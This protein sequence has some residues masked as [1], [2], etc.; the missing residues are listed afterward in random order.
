[1]NTKLIPIAVVIL[2]ASCTLPGARAQDFGDAVLNRVVS[3]FTSE[4]AVLEQ[5]AYT[6]P[7]NYAE[8]ICCGDGTCGCCRHC[9]GSHDVWGSVEYLMWWAKGTHMPPLVTTSDPGTPLFQAGILGLSTTSV[10]FGNEL[11][12]NE[13]QNGGRVTFGL[14]L[15]P[16]HDVAMGGRFFGLGGDTTR[17]SQASTG[18]PILAIPFFSPLTGPAASLIAYP[19]A[20]TGNVNVELSTH[21]IMGADAFVEIMMHRDFRR[22]VDFVGGYEFF[23]LDDLLQMNSES[24]NVIPGDPLNGQVVGLNDRFL[25]RNQFHGGAVGLRGRMANGCWSL[26]VLGQVALGNM[27]Q[28]ATINGTTVITQ[29]GVSNTFAGGLLAAPTNSGEFEQDS[30]CAIPQIN[31]NLHYHVTP[32]LSFHIGYNIMWLTSVA[33]SAEQVDTTVNPFLPLGPERPRF[34][35]Q[36][37]EYWLQG[38]NWG[39]NWDF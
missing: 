31:G 27:H 19:G 4:P 15:D 33:L 13:M 6:P 35:F 23:R 38:M 14:W 3:W 30:F 25:T 36:E 24:T 29:G 22:R 28:T 26:N 17:F 11:G 32:H 39:M 18:D 37:R 21:N 16:Q 9:Q 7:K 2:A 8:D 5:P 12:G 1:M 20:F 34:V 10:L